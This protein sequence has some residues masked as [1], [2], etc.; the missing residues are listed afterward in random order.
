M[1]YKSLGKSR[2]NQELWRRLRGKS[3][4][5]E[6]SER[7]IYNLLVATFGQNNVQRDPK[8]NNKKA[9]FL[10]KGIDVYI[11]VFSI[12]DITSDLR[13]ETPC[14]KNVTL[15]ELDEKSINKT[16]DRIASKILHECEQLPD[17]KLNV[18]IAKGEGISISSDD[19]IDTLI[20][21]PFL[22]INRKTLNTEKKLTPP[23]FRT[24]SELQNALAKISAVIAYDAVCKHGKLIGILGDNKHNARI[25]LDPKAFST[26][27]SLMCKDPE[28]LQ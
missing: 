7:E 28:C 12:K 14:S 20:G 9:D 13:E 16:L 26:I 3:G 19:I 4:G 21:R 8:V 22:T 18:L 25:P 6:K 27:S 5:K 15:F 17:S 23:F 1:K 24:E 11:E 10:V 2:E